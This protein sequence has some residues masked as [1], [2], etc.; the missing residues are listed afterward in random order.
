MS[1][2][3][4]KEQN[5]PEP[6]PLKKIIGPSFI[7][8]GLGLGSGEIIL[9]PYLTSHFGMG[10]I[11]GA[12]LGITFQ[13]FINMEIERYTLVHGESIFV[14]FA[15][16]YKYLPLWFLAST[17]IPWVWPGIIASSAKLIGS[18]FG[19]KETQYLAIVFL[20]TIGLILSLGKTLYKTVERFQ[21]VLIS[22]GVPS[23]FILTLLIAKKS[24]WVALAKGVVG[25][26]DGYI[27][28]PENIAIISFLAAL[29]YAGA[30]GNLNLAQSFY[31]REKGYGMGKFAM[32]LSSLLTGNKQKV[33][34]EGSKFEP[35]KENLTNFKIWWKNINTEHFAV[36]WFTGLI[37]I[38]LLALLSFSTTYNT[39][40]NLSDITFVLSE[41][42]A[43]GKMLFPLAGLIFLAI[44]G[45][46]LFG[47]QLTV[48]D[49][50][51]RI[52]TENLILSPILKIKEKNIS[53]IYFIVLWAQIFTGILIFMLG[54]TEP[55]K[56]LIIAAVLNAFAM[57]IHTGLTF[58]TNLTLLD[59]N[60]RPN[61]FR[62]IA[63]I[64]ALLFYG[65]FSIYVLI[66]KVI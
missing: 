48:L 27:V 57:F 47:T 7:L 45:L 21:K 43:I 65:G 66:E 36:F 52:L 64:S 30:G 14:G 18:I 59:K 58:W 33:S 11:W 42:I 60:L 16:K 63:I 56:L 46:T 53:K 19:F 32:K 51:S 10:I 3:P 12:I 6:L 17:F 31:I 50:T 28:L 34:L 35:T 4:L 26:G 9:W 39:N 37:T 29:A 13:F 55:L 24:H 22:I 41:S 23:I 15:R 8:L 1:L 2:E 44:A 38:V 61:L 40:N 5:I 62:K 25:I 20:I 49:A 54:L